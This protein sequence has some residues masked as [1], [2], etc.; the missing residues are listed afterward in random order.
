MMCPDASLCLMMAGRHGAR[1]SDRGAGAIAR[2]IQSA[3]YIRALPHLKG[4]ALDPVDWPQMHALGLWRRG[5]ARL[6]QQH[7]CS[8]T[9][10][11]TRPLTFPI[12]ERRVVKTQHIYRTSTMTCGQDLIGVD[13]EDGAELLPM[14]DDGL[15]GVDDGAVHVE[16]R[17][18]TFN[19]LCGARE[20]GSL[21]CAGPVWERMPRIRAVCY[22]VLHVDRWGRGERS[23]NSTGFQT[24]DTGASLCNVSTEVIKQRSIIIL[25][26]D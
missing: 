17:A 15:R 12:G 19:H 23:T 6:Q 26:S 4:T 14:L 5:E 21:W 16:E 20:G 2:R 13:A 25:S 3:V 9:T 10:M 22:W 8:C 7:L 1:L 11:W 18:R 24:S